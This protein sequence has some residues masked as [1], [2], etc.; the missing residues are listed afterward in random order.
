VEY[1]LWQLD[2]PL[3]SVA[4]A[5]LQCSVIGDDG[6]RQ[7]ETLD[8]D[9]FDDNTLMLILRGAAGSDLD[10]SGAKEPSE[11]SS[12]SNAEAISWPLWDGLSYAVQKTHTLLKAIMETASK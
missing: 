12:R 11:C 4:A 3:L 1:P 10:S 7:L 2:Q 6:E 9:F 5:L 8:M